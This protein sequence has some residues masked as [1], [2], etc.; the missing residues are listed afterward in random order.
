MRAAAIMLYA[1]VEDARVLNG[2]IAAWMS[3]GLPIDTDVVETAPVAYFGAEMPGRPALFIDTAEAK[4][5]LAAPD[6]LL[7]SVRSWPEHIGETSGYHYIEP[8][9]RIPGAVFGNGGSDAYHMENYRNFDFT[10]W[11]YH[12]GEDE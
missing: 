6:A 4:E 2:G 8:K 5:Y 7:V 11:T 10:M 12:E 9:G 1:G 3:A